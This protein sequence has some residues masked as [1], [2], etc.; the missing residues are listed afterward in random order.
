MTPIGGM[1]GIS[2]L[3]W[4][5][6]AA[7]LDQ[8]TSREVLFGMLGPLAVAIGAWMLMERTYRR[9]PE[10]LTGVMAMALVGKMVF[11]GAYIAVML[12]VLSLRTVPFVVSFTSY[13]IGL[14]VIQALAL[15]RLLA[16]RTPASGPP[17]P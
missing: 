14:L 15:R 9:Q 1:A 4:F 8:Q 10:R 5:V 12:R 2:I 6:A 16:S 17:I 3:S 13:F 11:F 7:V